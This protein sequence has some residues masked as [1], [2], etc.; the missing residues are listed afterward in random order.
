[1]KISNKMKKQM[2]KPVKLE[3]PKHRTSIEERPTIPCKKVFRSA[4]DKANSR[5]G[6]RKAEREARC[7][8]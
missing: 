8:Y 7:E 5:Q 4:K 6:R 1:M 3:S 2:A